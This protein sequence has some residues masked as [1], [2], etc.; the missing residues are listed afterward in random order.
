MQRS[1]GYL[2]V[3]LREEDT[4]IN[5]PQ[6]AIAIKDTLGALN[7]LSL[8]SI[9]ATLQSQTLRKGFHHLLKASKNPRG[10]WRTFDSFNNPGY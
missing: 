10:L 3:S 1:T 5:P 9:N 2:M 8:P 4:R 6:L 7:F